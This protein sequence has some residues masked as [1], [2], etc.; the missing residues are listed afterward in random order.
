MKPGPK[1]GYKQSPEHIEKRKRLG[2]AHPNWL[3]DAITEKSGRSRAIRAFPIIGGCTKC[4]KARAERHHKNGNTA[5]N[6]PE[7]IEIVCRR[8]HMREDG[9]LEKVMAMARL[10]HPKAIAARSAMEKPTHCPK[11]HRYV[12][13]NKRGCGVCSICLNE[14]KRNKR[15]MDKQN[16]SII[17]G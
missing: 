10:N 4:G 13:E 7:N 8:C 15:R 12:K 5:D 14:Y 6:R 11:G 1:K 17:A 3:G 9:R 2:A 16:R